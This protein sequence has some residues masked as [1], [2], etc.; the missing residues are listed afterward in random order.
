LVN[1][2]VKVYMAIKK[3]YFLFIIFILAS[4]CLKRDPSEVQF[5]KTSDVIRSNEMLRGEAPLSYAS[6][7]KYVLKPKCMSCHSGP[8]AKPTNDP[9]DFS[10]YETAMVKRFVPLLIKGK[11]DTSRL[12]L[13]VESGEMPVEGVLHEKE[14]E[15]VKRWIE[16]CAPKN[17]PEEIPSDCPSD[18]DDDDDDDDDWD[19]DDDDWDDEDE[20]E[21]H[22][23]DDNQGDSSSDAGRK[24]LQDIRDAV[25]TSIKSFTTSQEGRTIKSFESVDATLK[26][27]G[28]IVTIYFSGKKK[29]IFLS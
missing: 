15:F 14:V 2:L 6:L 10:T 26:D 28:V 1:C 18:D 16:A 5:S 21:D 27:G 8:D 9:I 29:Y 11:P 4:G 23:G 3:I 20:D 17:E 13:T 19:D 24:K 12:F 25:S 7:K 22:S